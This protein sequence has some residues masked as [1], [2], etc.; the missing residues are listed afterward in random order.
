[1]FNEY[2]LLADNVY[3]FNIDAI[4]GDIVLTGEDERIRLT[5]VEVFKIFCKGRRTLLCDSA[6]ERHLARKR[7]LI[8]GFG[9]TMPV[10]LLK[11]TVW[12]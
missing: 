4:D 12:L 11:K 9:N 10:P 1:M 5:I 3:S 2:P 6:D 8:F 7:N